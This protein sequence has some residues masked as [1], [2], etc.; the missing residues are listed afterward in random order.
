[1]RD[2]TETREDFSAA[3]AIEGS[4]QSPSGLDRGDEEALEQL[5][6]DTQDLDPRKTHHRAKVRAALFGGPPPA[7]E[8]IARYRI[9]GEIGT[10]AMG[11][12]L[13]AYDDVLTRKVAVK[14]VHRLRR[15]PDASS[16]MLQ[17][18]RSLAQL[19]HPNVVQVY[20]AGMLNERAWI[21][22]EYIQG[23]NLTTWLGAE[24][25]TAERVLEVFIEA[26]RGLA[27]AHEAGLVHRDFKPDNV[28]IDDRGKV[29]V[30]D[31]GLVRTLAEPQ[32][33]SGTDFDS[34]SD[35]GLGTSSSGT[36]LTREGTVLG[37]P[38]YMSPEQIRGARVDARS[39]QFSFCA[40]AWSG[41]FGVRPF[42]GNSLRHLHY[43]M[44]KGTLQADVLQPRGIAATRRA[45][46]RGL[47]FDPE[48]R[49]PS[50]DALLEQL[51]RR[52][53]HRW[54]YGASVAALASTIAAANWGADAPC[55]EDLALEDHGTPQLRS[56]IRDAFAN[57]GAPYADTTAQAVAQ[58]MLG[59]DAEL[60]RA[61]D[62]VC[63]GS[64]AVAS[65]AVQAQLRC[66]AGRAS[67]LTA[68]G[69]TF[70]TA[71][72]TT[73][74]HA[75]DAASHLPKVDRCITLAEDDEPQ[76][77]ADPHLRAA[78]A[79]AYTAHSTG[80]PA[81]AVELSHELIRRAV[82]EHDPATE[83]DGLMLRSLSRFELGEQDTA[84][85]DLT[86]AIGR[87]TAARLDERTTEAWVDLATHG[88]QELRDPE[89]TA[90]WLTQASAW[91]ERTG[92]E[93]QRHPLELARG[94]YQFLT[95]PHE[96]FATYDALVKALEGR[97][98]LDHLA[99]RARTARA[100]VAVQ[101]G[102]AQ[103][104]VGDARWLRDH[105]EDKYGSGHPF[106]S[107]AEHN[108]GLA[109]LH[110][111]DSEA[112]EHLHR[113]I[114]TWTAL[115]PAGHLEMVK[116]LIALADLD[117]SQGRIDH[118]R[119]KANRAL[120]LQQRLGP[121]QVGLAENWTLLG[122]VDHSAG[123]FEQAAR[124]HEHAVEIYE[125]KLGAADYRTAVA[126]SNLGEA[127]V[128][129]GR[130][131]QARPHFETAL[132]GLEH[133]VGTEHPT[134]AFPLK[135]AGIAALL[136]GNPQDAI[137]PLE[138]AQALAAKGD[139]V[140]RAEIDLAL[141]HAWLRQ[142]DSERGATMLEAVQQWED[143]A[144]DLGRTRIQRLSRLLTSEDSGTTAM[145]SAAP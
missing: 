37:T 61:R 43:A 10:G 122:V 55:G 138:R 108:L 88:G 124:A 135:S 38:G 92:S 121:D 81:Q 26:G 101:L 142:G 60:R 65:T 128:M 132:T 80:H 5:G 113:S 89:A 51:Q 115:F 107:S 112:A 96:A 20:E 47:S 77:P 35:D 57:T 137:A 109:L 140:E 23:Q 16:R 116:S 79:A 68:L 145:P 99:A 40:A 29:K 42:R 28:L 82:V 4:R 66:L 69:A 84:V 131:K 36:P 104:A 143:T 117:L 24:S 8:R 14:L 125:A 3:D 39:D 72:A 73:V 90:M 126:H 78:L 48:D 70:S 97:S 102:N 33:L 1:M 44:H 63:G 74:E 30:V 105:M 120:A 19:S 34:L 136:A 11:E 25:R 75:I 86:A 21:A 119:D 56:S 62:T 49:F 111:G 87:A 6:S 22:M 31:F 46:L 133:V 64:R 71:D 118:A 110:S 52:P 54:L 41:L 100:M 85:T 139:P 50:M 114:T 141:G 7:P 18:A 59:Y 76:G 15:S 106:T 94:H 2:P 13:E 9:L 144:T 95:A 98:D 32:T 130:W 127:M 134:L 91:V 103:T 67:A 123:Q 27:A 12:V 83:V 53:R 129:G 93:E 45:L 17:E 58:T